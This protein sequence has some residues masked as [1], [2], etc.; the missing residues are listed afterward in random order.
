MPDHERERD[1][2]SSRGST[3]RNEAMIATYEAALSV[4]SHLE[5]ADVLQ[6][7]ADLSRQI[8]PAKYSALGV[9]DAHGRIIDFFTSGITPAERTQ[10]GPIPEGHGL[11]GELVRTAEPLLV[12]D[13]TQHPKSIGFPENHPP[14]KS[15]LG[16]PILL[17]TRVL[18]NLYL[19]ERRDG[20]AF[21]RDDL[22]IIQMLAVHAAS[23]IERAQLH[24]QVEQ[25]RINAIEQRDQFR[26][27]VDHL[28][29]GVL[30]QIPPDG[31]VELAN[32]AALRLLLGSD[33]PRGVLPR[34]GHNFQLLEENRAPLS[35]ENRLDLLA[36]RG[37]PT[38]N[39]RLLLERA[40]G[41]CVSLL[42][43]ASPLRNA[44]GVVNRAV[45]VFQDITQL[46]E[47]EQMKD[48]FLSLV[49]HEFRT[50][51]T[52]IMG[53]ARLLESEGDRMDAGLRAELIGDVA[54]ESD[55]LDRMLT[56][57]LSLAAIM[58]GRLSPD[59][60]PVLMRQFVRKVSA[61]A[62]RI[63]PDYSFEID[64]APDLPPAE[65]DVDL[66]GQVMRNLYENAVKY[67]PDGRTIR[68]TVVERNGCIV[69]SV[70]DEGSGIASQHVGSV[71]ERFRR[72]GADPTVRGMGLGLYLSRHLVE[73]Q[74][75]RI[76]AESPGVGFGAT[77]SI[78]LPIARE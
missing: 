7:I 34:Y 6:R 31:R 48:D 49:S 51:L 43:Q 65:A 47:A 45:L 22:E 19:T 38:R 17:G 37:V 20:R 58:A 69:L 56:N 4:A 8:V 70:Q 50:P 59:T 5:L 25:A 54:T 30:I 11:L 26:V 75:G 3:W 73:V 71:F 21:D 39:R 41:T 1:A 33:G 42:C 24:R 14:M 12:P 28:P 72:P 60:E 2:S 66:L 76:W 77:F 27:L 35:A 74:G 18:G 52:A 44:D 40:D 78:E 23:A 32:E 67:S 64:L 57:M 9:A 53:G 55:R 62:A 29:A 15:L 16:V 46:R 61:E 63:A 68:T 13:L 36:L 10:I